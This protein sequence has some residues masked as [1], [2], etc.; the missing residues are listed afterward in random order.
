ML[1]PFTIHIDKIEVVVTCNNE[2]CANEFQIA[3]HI[4]TS[5]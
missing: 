1:S 4:V 2:C 5:K 3:P